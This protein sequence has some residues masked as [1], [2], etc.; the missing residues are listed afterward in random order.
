MCERRTENSYPRYIDSQSRVPN[1]FFQSSSSNQHHQ[2]CV[3][4]VYVCV[5]MCLCVYVCM[6]A[7]VRVHDHT[8]AAFK[9]SAV[10]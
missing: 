9:T 10:L 8:A 1:N 6:C 7:C 5:C 3:M 4:R 2:E